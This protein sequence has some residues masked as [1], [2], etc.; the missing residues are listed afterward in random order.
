MTEPLVAESASAGGLPATAWRRALVIGV[1]IAVVVAAAAFWLG[2]QWGGRTQTT[3][4]Y[5][6]AIAGSLGCGEERGYTA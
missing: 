3:T 6:S 5:C 4:A 2:A 1:V